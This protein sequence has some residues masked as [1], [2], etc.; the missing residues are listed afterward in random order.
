M[1]NPV[2]HEHTYSAILIEFVKG[3]NVSQ[4]GAPDKMEAWVKDLR[5]LGAAGD[6]FFSANE[7]IMM[8]LRPS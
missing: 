4:G 3:Y 6:Y 1:F 2:F 8:G 5:T 7:Y